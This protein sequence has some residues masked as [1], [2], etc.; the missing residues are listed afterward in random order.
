M[1][2]ALV[3]H[4]CGQG[5]ALGVSVGPHEFQIPARYVLDDQSVLTRY[6]GGRGFT[7][8]LNPGASLKEQVI[9]A[10]QEE[11][12]ACPLGISSQAREMAYL[13]AETSLVDPS[14]RPYNAGE[15]KSVP[16][17]AGI[18][19]KYV[20]KPEN[21]APRTASSC[22]RVVEPGA[23]GGYCSALGRYEDLVWTLRFREARVRQVPVLA[24]EVNRLLR[25]WRRT[26]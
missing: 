14:P 12:A 18:E 22:S 16:V 11:K 4:G 15:L 10:V 26:G 23:L 25:S 20:T 1:F 9:V 13:C 21:G 3:L 8:I 24:F 17:V 6:F 5:D 2:V 19:W 7:F